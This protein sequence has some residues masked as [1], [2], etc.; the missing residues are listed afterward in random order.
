MY[1]IGADAAPDKT[2][3]LLNASIFADLNEHAVLGLELNNT[4]PTLQ[5]R[6]ENAMDFLILPQFHYEFVNQ[7]SFQ[8]AMGPRF[9]N[10]TVEYSA[11]V[12]L[13]QSF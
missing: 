6:D 9:A 11:V 7:F 5:K 4:D 8:V 13:I 1:E 2:T 10:D 3:L 12:R